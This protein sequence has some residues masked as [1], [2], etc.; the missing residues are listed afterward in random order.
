MAIRG[1][2]GEDAAEL[3]VVVVDLMQQVSEG[4]GVAIAR[5]DEASELC[6]QLL[7]DGFFKDGAAHDG[8][9]GEEA[10]EVA[11]GGFVEVAIRFFRSG[12]GDHRLAQLGSALDCWLDEIEEFRIWKGTGGRRGRV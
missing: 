5:A 8:A 1:E 6:R 12:R 4:S 9:R 10:A 2:I 11:T 3:E 7:L